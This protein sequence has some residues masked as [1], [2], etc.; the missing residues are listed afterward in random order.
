MY[1]KTYNKKYAFL[2]EFYL[3]GVITAIVSLKKKN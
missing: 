1:N 3:S 2:V